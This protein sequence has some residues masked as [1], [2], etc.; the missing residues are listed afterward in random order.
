MYVSGQY[1]VSKGAIPVIIECLDSNDAQICE[2]AIKTIGIILNNDQSCMDQEDR[3]T[4][5]RK[6]V[7]VLQ[8]TKD[9]IW[10]PTRYS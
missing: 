1:L 9:D 2:L 4:V 7:I 3:T 10:N 8:A 6:L 5:F